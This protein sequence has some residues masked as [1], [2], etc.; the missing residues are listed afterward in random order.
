MGKEY[1]KYFIFLSFFLIGGFFMLKRMISILCLCSLLLAGAVPV[2][3]Y[4]AQS[5][6]SSSASSVTITGEYADGRVLLSLISPS[7]TSLTKEGTTSFDKKI[8]I[9]QSTSL[10]N[11]G[12]LFDTSLSS[13]KCD[14]FKDKNFYVTEAVS[15]TYSTKELI[16]KLESKAYVVEA[17]PDYKQYLTSDDPYESEQ[18][19]LDGEGSYSSSGT[20][21]SLSSKPETSSTENPVI[22]IMDTGINASHE[23]LIDHL[24]T[25]TTS[26]LKGTYGYDFSTD[27]ADCSDT[28]GHGTH[29][30]GVIAAT[31]DNQKGIHGISNAKLMALKIFDDKKECYDSYIINALTYLQQAKEAGVPVA[32]VNCSWGGGT[33]ST[34]M[35]TLIRSLGQSG[36]LFVFAAGNDGK[37]QDTAQAECPYD[38]YNTAAYSDLRN[39]ILTVGASDTNDSAASFSDYG[40]SSVDLFAPGEN[41]VSTYNTDTYFPELYE[42]DDA[43]RDTLTNYYQSFDTSGSSMDFYTDWD[44][45]YQTSTFSKLTQDSSSDYYGQENGGCLLW[46]LQ[47]GLPSLHR[48][49]AYVYVDVTDYNLDPAKDYYVSMMFGEKDSSSDTV[50]WEHVTKLSSGKLGSEGNRFYQASDG[51]LYFRVI[52]LNAPATSSG[53]T[54]LYLDNIGISTADPDTSEF[55]QYELLSGTSMAAP[56]V[57][58]AVALCAAYAPEE[59]TYNRRNRLLTCVRPVESLT[60]LCITGGIL[61]V[62]K[63][64]SYT[65]VETPDLTPAQIPENISQTTQ[66]TGSTSGSST[67]ETGSFSSSSGISSSSGTASSSSAVKV[68]KLK[69]KKKIKALRAGRTYRLKVVYTPSR[70]SNKKLKWS[71]SRKKWASVSNSGMV[72]AKKKGIGHTVRITAAARDGSR[73]KV[74]LRVKI[75][76]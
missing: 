60:D 23:D 37:N 67:V 35:K 56:M 51:H 40:K 46:D 14:F 54:T 74:S 22:A 30:A 18:W 20:G 21:I 25:N 55:G 8:R 17:S 16:Q 57:T 38:L 36:I 50:Q 9:E 68:K 31:T 33:S 24:W 48:K 4:A 10:G 32:A 69:F 26:S 2:S 15:D 63:I 47:M 6:S 61:D 73:K 59:D 65:T 49:Q 39:Y 3:S 52:G 62:S 70:V 27:S 28:S 7:E 76:K 71:S 34:A 42:T 64:S 43:K 53:T 75:R 5:T 29:C 41:I 11:A 19:Y 1:N 12:E 58:G 13:D 44:V 45:G 72:R 66:T